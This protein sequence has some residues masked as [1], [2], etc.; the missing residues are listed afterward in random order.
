MA[1]VD[2]DVP[3]LLMGELLRPH[4]RYIA[5]HIARPRVFYDPAKLDGDTI[6]VD[7][8]HFW[9]DND[10]DPNASL[11]KDARVRRDLQIVGTNNSRELSK[12]KVI[13]TIKEYTGPSDPNN[14]R[15]PSTFRIPTKLLEL[16]QHNYWQYGATAFH[17]SIGSA[18]LL[19]DFKR[20]EDRVYIEEYLKTTFIR[21]PNNLALADGTAVNLANYAG[22][23]PRWTVA[24]SDAVVTDMATRNVPF[25]EDGNLVCLASFRF[26][27]DIKRDSEFRDIAR[28][29]GAIP[30]TQMA[31][32]QTPGQPDQIMFSAGKMMTYP[33]VY[34][35]GHMGGQA[36]STGAMTTM[37]TGFVFNGV[38]YFASSNM[39]T[40]VQS[41]NYS[42]SGD[43]NLFPNGNSNRTA[44]LGIFYGQQAIGVA[45]GGEG[46]SI[47][48]ANENNFQ[49][50][51]IAIWR[52][53]GEWKLLDSRFVTV[54]RSFQN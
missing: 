38:R 18:N 15:E 45:L 36:Y 54:G 2:Y 48:F 40:A 16:A 44:E 3:S 25:Y 51:E 49:R 34:Q 14:P 27:H 33:T 13:L 9:A 12:D 43:T 22:R 42:N 31:L 4:P 11:T 17:E 19:D 23:P 30:V 1:A 52:I 39:K 50:F 37:P 20:W 24:D 41:L 29:V 7:R 6:Q 26:L 5:K 35:V 10:V 53:L 21:N 28:E 46:P 47:R 8:F 32:P